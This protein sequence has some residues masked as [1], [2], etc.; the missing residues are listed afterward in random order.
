MWRTISGIFTL[1]RE[2]N[3]LL[4]EQNQLWR[5]AF[6]QLTQDVQRTPLPRLTPTK[7]YT[8]D[9]VFQRGSPKPATPA[10][11]P[12]DAPDAAKGASHAP[13]EASQT[14]SS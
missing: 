6:P 3:S 11:A 9:D 5:A 8:K 1:L 10:P 2:Q 12:A 4:R 13:A 14:P 7:V